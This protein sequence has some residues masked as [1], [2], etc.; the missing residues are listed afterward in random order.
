MSPS[1]SKIV[2]G[3]QVQE[4]YWNGKHVVYVDHRLVAKCFDDACADAAA[5]KEGQQP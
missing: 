4:Y 2:N 3:V 5:R 1:R